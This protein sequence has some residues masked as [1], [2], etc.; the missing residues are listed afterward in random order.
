VPGSL[1]GV[2]VVDV[3]VSVAG[4]FATQILGDLGADV[5][6]VERPPGGDDT[7]RWGPPFWG[8]DSATFQGLNRNKRS[9]LLDLSGGEDRD[10]LLEL[11]ADADV[12]VQNLRPGT[13]TKLGFGYADLRRLNPR[14]IYCE[15]SGYGVTGPLKDRPAYD[16]LMQAFGGLMSLTGEE[17]RPP[18]RVPASILDQGSAM[19]AVI[20]ILDALRRR[21]RTGE[22]ALVQTSLLETALMWLPPQ[23]M[24]YFAA[25][26]VP[27]RLGSATVGIAPYEAFP[28]ADGWLIVAAGNDHLWRQLCRA[29]RRDD[30]AE[31]PR[32]RANPDRV[33][34]RHELHEELAATFLRQPK[35]RWLEA[36]AA[37]G[38]P[39]TEVQSIDEVVGHEQVAAVGAIA[40]VPHPRLERFRVINTPVQVDG[41]RYPVRLVPPAVGEHSQEVRAEILARRA[42]EQPAGTRE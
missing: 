41:E 35:S 9:L 8:D 1:E 18:V 23:L 12:L 29:L 5:I 11:V 37:H 34:H 6:K 38:V 27:G 22:G 26:V 39:V 33:E 14:L 7:R 3:T 36:L 32:F 17:G 10:L 2:R 4:P 30:L 40:E 25:G 24:G 16:P 19:W 13:L 42:R 28:T 31:D 21:E 15:I 20:G